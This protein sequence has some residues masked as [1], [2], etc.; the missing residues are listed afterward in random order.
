MLLMAN[1]DYNKFLLGNELVE[2]KRGSFITSELKLMERWGWSKTKVR[3][4][5]SLLEKDKMIIKK[6]DKKKTTIIIENYN[7][8]Q[9]CETT[10]KPQKNHKETTE[11]PQEDTNKNDKN[12]ENDKED[13][14]NNL[15]VEESKKV[16]KIFTEND[17][18]YKLAQ[19]LSKQIAKRL[20]KSPKD[21]KT[22][23][24]W[25]TDFEK[26]VRLDGLD[27]IEIRDVLVFSQK[28]SFWQSNILS[29]SKFRKQYLTLLSKMK[30]SD[31]KPQS[32]LGTLLEMIDGGEFDE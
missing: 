7:D 9:A 13:I 11:K 28:D 31:K 5:L 3:S 2:I 22:L 23:Q 29:A 14:N 1:H 18:E 27:I 6:S 21:E 12:V 4:F 20:N 16:K 19:Y 24:S 10:E 15:P 25:S 26:M 8:Y 30:G 32:S 17:K